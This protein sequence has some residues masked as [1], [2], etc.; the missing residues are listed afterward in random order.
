MQS[1]PTGPVINSWDEWTQLREVIVGDVGG[2]AGFHLDPSFNLFYWENIK[3]F[4]AS[5]QFV[6]DKKG[7]AAWPNISIEPQIIDELKEDI[8]GFVKALVSVG[9][10]VRRPAPVVGNVEVQTPF[11]RSFQCPPLNIRDQ[12]I[13]LGS[14]IVETAPHVR[15]RVFENDYLRPL[16]V[17]YMQAGARW[18]NMPR[19]TLAYGTF[20]GSF[21]SFTDEES[22]ALTDYH[23]FAMAGLKR[24]IVFDGAQCIRIG[25][26]VLVNVANENHEMGFHWLERN[27]GGTLAFHRLYRMADSHVDSTLLPLRPGLWLVRDRKFLDFI[28]QPFRRWD[29]I[30]APPPERDLFPSYERNNLSIASKFI[31][32]NVL[33]VNEQTV[34]VNS[35]FPELIRKLEQLRFDVIPVRH[36]HRRLFGGG[37]HC[38][39]L[40]VRRSG[41]PVS[42]TD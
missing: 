17:E 32:M 21:F 8:Q 4:L 23:A 2:F 3:S 42:Y 16:F 27:C 36:R 34:I 18:I 1:V 6:R 31:D 13:I 5:R 14:T 40:D 38:F 33:S 29:C 12:T 41:G 11:W 7:V 25:T 9:V 30:V 35:L 24:E 10:V 15:S 26:D 19:P 28:P 22:A 39:T 20:D 37:F